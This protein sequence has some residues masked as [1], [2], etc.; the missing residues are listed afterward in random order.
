M[1]ES[2]DTQS[3]AGSIVSLGGVR[4]R[5]FGTGAA[6][7]ITPMGPKFVSVIGNDGAVARSYTANK[8]F[9]IEIELLPGAKANKYFT[10]Q[11]LADR[12]VCELGA[13][14]IALPFLWKGSNLDSF[15]T[16]EAWVTGE[17]VVK[18]SQNVEMRMWTLETGEGTLILGKA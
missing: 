9:K 7:T 15:V 5:A 16:G 1:S 6:I 14:G 10:A 3:L 13:G 12:M 17:P 4:I 8:S 11:L 18:M 2:L